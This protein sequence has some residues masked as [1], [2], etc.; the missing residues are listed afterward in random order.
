VTLADALRWMDV[1]LALALVPLCVY[2]ITWATSWDQ[3]LRFGTLAGY[4]VVTVAGQIN[5]LGQP[6]TWVTV[7]LGCVTI[8][9]VVGTA[10]YMIKARRDPA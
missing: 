7:L 1:A 8:A 4:G 3:R 9:A 2:C 5:A 6:L 10:V